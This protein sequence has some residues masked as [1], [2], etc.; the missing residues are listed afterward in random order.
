MKSFIPTFKKFINESVRPEVMDIWGLLE[1]AEP[2]LEGLSREEVE[3][4]LFEYLADSGH[5]VGS[6]LALYYKYLR[7]KR[8][9]ADGELGQMELEL[10]FSDAVDRDLF[11]SRR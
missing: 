2:E 6:P 9:Y 4:Y 5:Y 7:L 1:L 8:R 11:E 3:E 10:E